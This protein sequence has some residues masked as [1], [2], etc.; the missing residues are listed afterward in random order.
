MEFPITLTT[1][2]ISMGALLYSNPLLV[3]VA[4]GTAWLKQFLNIYKPWGRRQIKQYTQQY[5][6][7][8]VELLTETWNLR[9][10]VRARKAE[11][12]FQNRIDATIFKENYLVFGYYGG[13]SAQTI[14]DVFSA[15]LIF[16]A[17][18]VLSIVLGRDHM[19]GPEAV[20][21]YT[22][23]N[24]MGSQMTVAAQLLG[25]L[26]MLLSD[27]SH[28]RDFVSDPH[29]ESPLDG[30][31]LPKGWP[32]TGAVQFNDVVFNYTHEM[33]SNKA[34]DHLTVDISGAATRA[35]CLHTLRCCIG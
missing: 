29:E 13:C 27:Y 26:D 28:V 35:S 15:D 33:P 23:I 32:H 6:P 31:P 1:L 19:N 2:L 10:A 8:M 7:Q 4:I 25:Q 34:I 20:V 17:L 12:F 21:L 14:V 3:P 22:L 5:Q 11:A 24:R 30:K 16:E 18:A 9:A